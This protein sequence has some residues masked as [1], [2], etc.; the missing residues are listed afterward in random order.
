MRRS[1]RKAYHKQVDSVLKREN[2]I[3]GTRIAHNYL[4]ADARDFWKEAKKLRGRQKL[5]ITDVDRLTDSDE[6]ADAFSS[7]YKTLYNS[8][9]FN[10]DDMHSLYNDVSDSICNCTDNHSHKIAESDIGDAIRKLK[11]GKGDGYD[12]LTSDYL[13]NPGAPEYRNTYKKTF[14]VTY[15]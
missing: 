7:Y 6:I 2:K 3:K 4:N 9:D 15:L 1:T 10:H 14:F 11:S 12:G 5:P 13:I 8:V